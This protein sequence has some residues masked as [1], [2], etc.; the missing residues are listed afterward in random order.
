MCADIADVT[1]ADVPDLDLVTVSSPC[2]DVSVAGPKAGILGSRS[3]AFFHVPRILCEIGAAGRRLPPLV[4]FENVTGILRGGAEGLHAVAKTL[5]VLGYRIGGMVVDAVHFVPQSRPRLILVGA[6]QDL[7]LQGLDAGSHDDVWRPPLLSA[8]ARNVPGWISWRLPCPPRER[9]S[10]AD[11]LESGD[12]IDWHSAEQTERLLAQ[13]SVRQLEQLDGEGPAVWSVTRRTRS[14]N[15]TKKVCAELRRDVASCLTTGAGGSSRPTVLVRDGSVLR[16]RNL[17]GREAARLMGLPDGFKVPSSRTAAYQLL[18]DAV[19]ADVVE[20]VAT[21]L[22]VPL[23][24]RQA[25]CTKPI[26]HPARR[27]LA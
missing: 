13:I 23:L 12:T 9:R 7:D 6:Q 21:N 22:L 4:L 3:K 27:E 5:S 2:V 10:L 26:A 1:S 17:T 15:G 20:F 18:G 14:Q 24:E 16:S 11:L 19:V 25:A 8:A